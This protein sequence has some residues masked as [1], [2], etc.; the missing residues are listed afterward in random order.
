MQSDDRG[1]RRYLGSPGL[2]SLEVGFAFEVFYAAPVAES[3]ALSAHTALARFRAVLRFPVE[4]PSPEPA[5]SRFILP[6]RPS[7]SEFLRSHLSP[8]VSRRGL[9]YPGSRPSSRHNQSASTRREGCQ[10]L[11]SFRPQVFS[12][13]RRFSPPSGFA[14]FFH[15]AATSRVVA[16]QGLLSPRSRAPSSRAASPLPL[17]LRALTGTRVVRLFGAPLVIGCHPRSVRLRGFDPRGA[18]LSAARVFASPQLAPLFGFFSSRS[19]TAAV[20]SSSPEPSARNDSLES[21]SCSALFGR[22]QRFFSGGLGF[23]VSVETNLPE[24]FEPSD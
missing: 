13:S 24:T 19:S 20:S 4:L 12:T 8:T 16:V 14:G 11:A 17:P 7:S 5:S 23:S 1:A 22:S 6:W 21:S 10:A 15:P 3:L 2:A 9:T 18:A